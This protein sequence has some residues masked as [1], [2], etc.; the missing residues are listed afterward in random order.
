M[1]DIAV[2]KNP[3]KT[4]SRANAPGHESIELSLMDFLIGMAKRKKQIILL[5]LVAGVVSAALSF[6]LPNIYQADTKLLPPQQAQSGAAALLSQLGGMAGLA[7]SS[8]G[9]KNPNDL[10]IGMLRSRT[11]ADRLIEQFNLRKIYDTRSNEKARKQLEENTAIVAGKD[12]IITIEVQD[13]DQQLVARLAN[14]YVS[15]L[16]KLTSVLAITEAGQRRVFFERQLEQAKNNLANAEVALKGALDT[17]GVVSV[18]AESRSVLETVARLRAQISADEIKLNSMRAFVTSSHPEFKET[19][20]E[21]ASLRAELS[22]LENGRPDASRNAA[23]NTDGKSGLENI[24]LLRN[25]KYYQM[26]YE[27]LA[28][29][30]EVARLDEA[31]GSTVVQV[32]DPAVVPERKFKPKRAI[33]VI[34]SASFTFLFT[35]LWAFAAE[36]REK[37]IRSGLQP[38]SQ[39]NELLKHLGFR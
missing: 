11:V 10:Y 31:N 36:A 1:N 15:E 39:W 13:K 6:A 18:D 2:E 21:L 5:P 32:L 38:S 4:D 19:T 37:A 17:H 7:A 9:L 34:L 25:V 35:A 33:I 30:Y 27:L 16:L 12:G 8:A 14:A 20:E 29:Q 23:P 26:L 24:K 22:R 3:S 28:K